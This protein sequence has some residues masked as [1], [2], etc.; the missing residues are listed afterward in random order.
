MK[1][2]TPTA[3]AFDCTGAAHWLKLRPHH[4]STSLVRCR[5]LVEDYSVGRVRYTGKLQDGAV[6]VHLQHHRHSHR[7]FD[8]LLSHRLVLQT[9][10]VLHHMRRGQLRIPSP[11]SG[12]DSR[13]GFDHLREMVSHKYIKVFG[14]SS[15]NPHVPSDY[16]P[17][18]FPLDFC[19]ILGYIILFSKH[20]IKK[21]KQYKLSF[22]Q[23]YVLLSCW[24]FANLLLPYVFLSLRVALLC[25]Y[26]FPYFI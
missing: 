9:S 17:S 4:L 24:I 26:C 18:D 14:C 21:K 7:S 5:L 3:F 19:N 15:F 6:H 10:Q 25:Y 12:D 16:V 2:W 11:T 1:L 23:F 8:D 20:Y 13:N 22:Y